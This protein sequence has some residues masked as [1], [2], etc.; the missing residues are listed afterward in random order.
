MADHA[1]ERMLE[2]ATAARETREPNEVAVEAARSVV[3]A[4]WLNHAAVAEVR[5]DVDGGVAV[6][7]GDFPRRYVLALCDNEGSVGAVAV[8]RDAASAAW[9]WEAP[10]EAREQSTLAFARNAKEWLGGGS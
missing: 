7:A 3:N 5:A 1:A 8:T 2:D 6:Y 10:E 4:L 9:A